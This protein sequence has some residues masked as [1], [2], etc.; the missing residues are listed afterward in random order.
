MTIKALDL[1]ECLNK[2]IFD[3]EFLDQSLVNL[4]HDTYYEKYL[5]FIQTEYFKKVVIP[6]IKKRQKRYEI[7]KNPLNKGTYVFCL[8]HY[9]T[10]DKMKKILS[11][12]PEILEIII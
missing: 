9:L 5:L 6:R 1:K 10:E 2:K 3:K 7:T 8:R 12:C 4:R 11:V